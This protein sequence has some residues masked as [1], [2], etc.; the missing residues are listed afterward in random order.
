M[1]QNS[2]K[3][4]SGYRALGVNSDHVPCVIRYNQKHQETYVITSVGKAFHVYK[5]SRITK[6]YHGK[7]A[8][9]AQKFD[10]FLYVCVKCSN[11]GLTRVSDLLDDEISGLAADATFIYASS[12]KNIYAFRF[13]RKVSL[14]WCTFFY[15]SVNFSA[16]FLIQT[17]GGC[18]LI[19]YYFLMCT[20][21]I[22]K[23]NT[24]CYK[25]S[26]TRN[27]YQ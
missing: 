9:S 12:K 23:S 10:F 7:W 1:T 27:T 26:C 4:F 15:H 8:T 14:L 16:K 3:I 24:E 13:G 21:R 20:K 22:L 19:L 18:V 2:S 11:L 17:L 5:V 25:T 6:N